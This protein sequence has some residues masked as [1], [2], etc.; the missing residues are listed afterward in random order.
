M[1]HIELDVVRNKQIEVAVAVVIEECATGIEAGFGIEQTG[2]LGHIG[3]SAVAA[4]VV[5]PI[6]AEIGKK[7]I[8]EAVVIVVADAKPIGPS[9]IPQAGLVGNV[10]ECAIA[11]VVIEAV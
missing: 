8:L 10:G 7:E 2:L 4:V 9:R 3:K 11:I 6:L 1:R 5:E